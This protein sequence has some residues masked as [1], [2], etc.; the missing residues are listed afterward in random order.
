[1]KL[2]FLTQSYPPM[3]S[4]AS[5]FA[6]QLAK[7]MANRGYTVL[8]I[9]ASDRGAAYLTQSENMS[10]LRLHSAN[11]PL[12][13]GQRF[14]LPVR[15]AVLQALH[16][17]QPDLIHTHDP[18]QMGLTG[19]SYARRTGI[20]IT[21]SIHQLPWFVASYIPNVDGLRDRTEALLWNYARWVLQKFTTV[22]TPTQTITDIVTERTGICPQTISYGLGLRAFSASP[23][24][25]DFEQTLRNNLG[26]PPRVPVLLHGH[27]LIDHIQHLLAS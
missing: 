10:V 15:R 6:G 7:G 18:F 12:R 27:S 8:V 2:A 11:N 1:M 3:V 23:L 21:L 14:L 19:V 17:F 4:G 16:E 25:I 9:A 13:V 26:L 5:L 22:L 24:S 20:P